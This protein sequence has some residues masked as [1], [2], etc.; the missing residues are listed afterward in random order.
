MSIVGGQIAALHW[1]RISANFFVSGVK[2]RSGRG[3]TGSGGFP[4]IIGCS[5]VATSKNPPNTPFG[6]NQGIY[7][8]LRPVML[9]MNTHSGTNA[10]HQLKRTL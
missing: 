10:V 8:A 6:T 9:P 1:G 7:C 3:K 2:R 5:S 4:P